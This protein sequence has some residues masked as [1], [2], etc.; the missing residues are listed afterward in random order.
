MKTRNV[1]FI[2]Y[3]QDEVYNAIRICNENNYNYAMIYHDKDLKEDR[4]DFKKAHY[5]FQVFNEYQKE[6]TTWSDLFCVNLPRTQKIE[7]KPKAIRY[8]IH[9]DNNEKFQYDIQNIVSNFD[10]IRYFDKMINDEN[11][12]IDI[13]FSYISYH[14]RHIGVK[15]LIDYV[16]DNNIWGT[17]RRNYSIIKDLLYEHNLLFTNRK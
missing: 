11:N 13:I 5:H 10:F 1:E 6:L 8:L 7:N 2:L 14:K 4:E 9:A 12:E 3:E 16:L 15:E 17:F